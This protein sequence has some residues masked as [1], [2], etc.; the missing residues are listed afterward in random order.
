MI[1]LADVVSRVRT[2][3][4]Q[5]SSVRWLDAEILDSVKDG[6]E[7]IAEATGF[8]ETFVNLR[9][10]A[11]Q[12]YFD[13]RGVLPGAAI[14]VTKIWS[15]ATNRWLAY[16]SPRFLDET[17]VIWHNVAGG[18]TNWFLR[19]VNWLGIFP[20]LGAGDS[21]RVHFQGTPDA[22]TDLKVED[23]YGA[24]LEEYALYDLLCQDGE[25]DRAIE[26]WEA[27]SERSGGLGAQVERRVARARS[28][29][30]SIR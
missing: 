3:F 4:E 2:R 24:A 29:S 16:R 11:P 7:D 9:A 6:L 25:T 30:M 5:T 23:D 8:H 14:V 1:A 27:Y 22:V 10:K 19:G 12:T 15:P 26:R 28:S 21:V 18:P 17:Y 20:R 13:L